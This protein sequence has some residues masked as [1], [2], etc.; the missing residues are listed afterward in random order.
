MST[1]SN[2]KPSKKK[3][4]IK[5]HIKPPAFQYDPKNNR[6]ELWS[7]EVG[8]KKNI[9]ELL[10]ELDGKEIEIDNTKPSTLKLKQDDP[11]I[12]N[13]YT[14]S[15]LVKQTNNDYVVVPNEISLNTIAFDKQ[16][17]IESIPKMN[18]RFIKA[19]DEIAA[20]DITNARFRLPYSDVKQIDISKKRWNALGSNH[21]DA[22]FGGDDVVVEE[23][24]QEESTVVEV[25]D[26]SKN[27]KRKHD[28]KEEDRDKKRKKQEKKEK[29]KRKK[30]EK[31][32]QRV[33]AE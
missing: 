1:P 32:K 6:Y 22:A 29:K 24:R 12:N 18:N 2:N 3:I 14:I 9:L 30:G 33:K 5:E 4:E 17:K 8:G 28:S 19:P 20:P 21:G 11:T 27:K 23:E 26:K 7:I 25:E 15:T 16:C 31:H 13:E 10:N